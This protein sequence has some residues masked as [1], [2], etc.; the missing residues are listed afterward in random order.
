MQVLNPSV[1]S[2]V[3]SLWENDIPSK[4]GV[5]GWRLLL[6]KLPTRA[7]LASRSIL[8]NLHLH[9]LPCVFCFNE[10]EDCPHLFFKCQF[11]KQVWSRIFRWMGSAFNHFDEGWKHFN[12]FGDIVKSKRESKVKHLI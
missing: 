9:D 3:Q 11:M 8:T 7:A 10:V 6:E 5:F 2:A 1:L 4:V 12:F